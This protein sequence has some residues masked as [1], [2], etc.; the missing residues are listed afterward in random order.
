M[1]VSINYVEGLY[2]T[3]GALVIC[4]K[5]HLGGN[6]NGTESTKQHLQMILLIK[7]C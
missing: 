4:V 5:I 3:A 2:I 1:D 7:Q 6:C